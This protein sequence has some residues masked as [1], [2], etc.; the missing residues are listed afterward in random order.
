MDYTFEQLHSIFRN[1]PERVQDALFGIDSIEILAKIYAKHSLHVDQADELARQTGYIMLGLT[2]PADFARTLS[3]KLG[4]SDEKAQ[5][6]I[7]D[8]NEKIFAPIQ[9]ELKKSK[10]IKERVLL[11]EAEEIGK[12]KEGMGLGETPGAYQGQ[13]TE[14][15]PSGETPAETPAATATTPT[16]GAPVNIPRDIFQ[17]RVGKLFRAPQ[18]AGRADTPTTNGQPKPLSDPYRE[19]PA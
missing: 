10:A 1:L 18:P 6:I 11:N 14:T 8:I 19:P 15:K 2:E 4:L 9:E 3:Q 17:E 5:E 13:A 12:I 7:R 16:G